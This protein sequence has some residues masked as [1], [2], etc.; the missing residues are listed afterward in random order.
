V[1]ADELDTFVFDQIRQLLARPELLT[2]GET[3]LAAGHTPPTDD[4]LLATQLTRLQR[5]VQAAHAERGRVAD[6]YQA[7]VIDS[8]EMK[9][10]SSEI[11][12]RSRRLDQEH[13]TLLAR[14]TELATNNQ[15]HH[16]IADFAQRTPDGID[17]L[18][19]D[20]RQQLLRL[21]IEDVRV[22]G[23]NVE[24]RPRIPLDDNPPPTPLPYQPQ[25][26]VEE[27]APEPREALDQPRTPCQAMTV[28]VPLANRRKN[29]P[30]VEGARTSAN[31]RP[32]P[33][34]RSRS[35]SLM[36]SAPATIPAINAT[37][38]TAAFPPPLAAIRTR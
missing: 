20:S 8:T 14:Q 27:P 22:R 15:L 1:R 25:T 32:I 9:R 36:L 21:V 2:A 12:A 34:W 28:C 4:E 19:F 31:N 17:T 11:D 23:W 38:F 18:D 37:I 6:L 13:Q 3:A 35:M 7:G 24:L 33:P 10:R 30:N 5:R 26:N 29:V 16:G